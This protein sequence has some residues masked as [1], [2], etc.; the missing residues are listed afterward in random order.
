MIGYIEDLL[1][2]QELNFTNEFLPGIRPKFR[3][4]TI[5]GQMNWILADNGIGLIPYF[6][7]HSGTDMVSVLPDYSISRTFWIQLNPDSKRV[8]R[9]RATIDFIVEEM[10]A[11]KLILSRPPRTEA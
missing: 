3:S 10:E 7:A 9:V 5:V 1:Y 4:S 11:S 6:M 8:A 2:D